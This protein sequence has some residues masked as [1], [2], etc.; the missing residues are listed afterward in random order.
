MPDENYHGPER[1]ADYMQLEG[2]LLEVEKLHGAVTTL[3]TAVV[4]TV[5][6]REL[7]GIREEVAK[8]FKY[9]VYLQ[10]GLTIVSLLFLMLYY[11]RLSDIR[12]VES[13]KAHSVIE[14]LLTLPEASRTGT[15]GPT[16]IVTCEAT[17]K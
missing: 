4:N 7:E 9:K 5:P 6:R 13:K 10:V 15:L 2:A 14:C 11:N 1:R 16:S 8:D 3:A 17:A 12:Q